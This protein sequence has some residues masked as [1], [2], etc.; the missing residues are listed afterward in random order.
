MTYD[1]LEKQLYTFRAKCTRVV[2]GDTAQITLDHGFK[3]T[4]E[5]RVRLLGVDTPERNQEN[6]KEATAFTKS[7][8]EGA[9]IYVQTFKSDV[10]GRYLA[11]VYYATD[12]GVKCLND[13]L[14]AQGLVKPGSKWNTSDE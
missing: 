4:S 13:E 3:T 6:W 5:Q 10:F 2:D 7:Q 14:Y 9:D 12:E 11:K 1:D 8:I